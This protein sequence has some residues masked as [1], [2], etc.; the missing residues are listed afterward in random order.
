M[1]TAHA[2]LVGATHLAFHGDVTRERR[3]LA[4]AEGTRAGARDPCAARL[5]T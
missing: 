1:T 5:M 2:P 4:R 3:L